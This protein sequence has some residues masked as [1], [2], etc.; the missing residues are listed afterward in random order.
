M[1]QLKLTAHDGTV[2][3]DS[4]SIEADGTGDDLGDLIEIIAIED[5]NEDGVSQGFEEPLASGSYNANNGEFVIRFSPNIEIEEDESFYLLIVYNMRNSAS[6]GETF[7]V[8]LSSIYAENAN[9]VFLET[10]F[11][12]FSNTK[13]IVAPTSQPGGNCNNGVADY[14]TPFYE[15]GIDC[16]GPFCPPCPQQNPECNYN[17]VADYITPYYEGG[18]DCGGPFCPPCIPPEGN[19]NINGITDYVT[20]FYEEGIDCGGPYCPPCPPPLCNPQPGEGCSPYNPPICDTNAET[21]SIC[22]SGTW[23]EVPELYTQY[24]TSPPDGC[25]PTGCEYGIGLCNDRDETVII[26]NEPGYWGT[27]NTELYLDYCENNDCDEGDIYC[28]DEGSSYIC[29]EDAWIPGETENCLERECNPGELYCDHV[30]EEVISCN[31]DGN[32]E[33]LYREESRRI[34]VL[35]NMATG[36]VTSDNE[37]EDGIDEDG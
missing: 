5:A 20:P 2:R 14:I 9:G 25:N 32:W 1:L 33:G 21:V 30:E 7:T 13:T 31:E 27:P 4:I 34:P 24:C 29:V 35:S 22:I 15:Q 19:C 16:G 6:I 8:T 10:D 18:I 37:G 11:S 28:S 36:R 23:A 26:C 17:G 12:R 3:I